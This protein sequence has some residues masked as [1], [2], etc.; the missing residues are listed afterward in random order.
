MA[1]TGSRASPW[2]SKWSPSRSATSARPSDRSRA[3][4]KPSWV[5]PV[6]PGLCGVARPATTMSS[7]WPPSFL[8][9]SSEPLTEHALVIDRLGK[10][11]DRLF[12]MCNRH[13]TL[14]T[15]LMLADQLV[16]LH[17]LLAP[18]LT[19]L[20]IL[21]DHP[22]RVHPLAGSRTWSIHHLCAPM[23]TGWADTSRRQA[24]QLCAGH[25]QGRGHRE[26]HRLWAGS[27]LPGPSHE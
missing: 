2:P 19:S 24:G 1:R 8:P 3:F 18:P 4:T 10:D 22:A 5:V 11:L 21:T 20:T 13:F 6:C 17:V 15:V 27:A 7:V 26:R 12:K 14:K 23:L 9:L 16:S 25:G